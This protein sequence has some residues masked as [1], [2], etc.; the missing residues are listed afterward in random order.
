MWMIERENFRERSPGSEKSKWPSDDSVTS[1]L[2]YLLLLLGR[3]LVVLLGSTF[4]LL[5]AAER[6]PESKTPKRNAMVRYSFFKCAKTMASVVAT[7]DNTVQPLP[8]ISAL[9]KPAIP[10]SSLRYVLSLRIRRLH[11]LDF[12]TTTKQARSR[13]SYMVDLWLLS[14]RKQIAN[15]SLVICEST[16]ARNRIEK[17]MPTLRL[18]RPRVWIEIYGNVCFQNHERFSTDQRRLPLLAPLAIS[19]LRGPAPTKKA[20][21]S[22]SVTSTLGVP[23]L[24]TRSFEILGAKRRDSANHD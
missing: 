15:E 6:Y 23:P 18:W 4:F 16:E 13:S 17:V 7:V 12:Q 8:P 3:R 24:N 19:V 20:R 11:P 10:V 9:R 14:R 21:P 22:Q 5:L 2:T 1:F